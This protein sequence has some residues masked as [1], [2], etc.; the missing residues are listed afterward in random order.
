[1]A[2]VTCESKDDGTFR[3]QIVGPGNLD[4]IDWEHI[5]AERECHNQTHYPEE[6]NAIEVDADGEVT[7][8]CAETLF[9]IVSQFF[10]SGI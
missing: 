10:P 2:D 7:I 5:E 9:Q 6:S 3:V 4:T 1:M 8:T